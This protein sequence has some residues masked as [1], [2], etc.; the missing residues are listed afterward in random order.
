MGY[1]EFA[2]KKVLGVPVLYVA[3]AA[4][5]ILVIV[6]WKM[7]A[8]G[9]QETPGVT[10][11]DGVAGA[12]SDESNAGGLAGMGNAYDGYN[13][14]GTVVVSPIPTPTQTAEPTFS[15]NDAWVKASAEWLVAKN[16]ASGTDASRALNKY[17]AGENLSF[18]EGSL[19]N[20]A[21]SEKGQPPD[22]IGQ[23]GTIGEQPARKQFA[24][25]NGTHTVQGTNDN[26][27][28]KLAALYYGVGD[29][30]HA[31]RIAEYNTGLGP[32]TTTFTAGTKVVIPSYV[33]PVYYTVTGKNSDNLFKTIAGKAGAS[34]PMIRALNP[35]LTEP[36]PN[37]TKVRTY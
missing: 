3:A 27:M 4:V 36:I 9:D 18:D 15:D 13:S 14:N 31:N 1:D 29:A 8:V 16:K 11:E 7:K 26:T 21:I 33:N 6:A 35:S 24:G 17:V 19:V 12:E 5:T 34:V 20:A 10:P 30:L 25:S 32:V 28:P 23:I 22:P 37:G 2:K